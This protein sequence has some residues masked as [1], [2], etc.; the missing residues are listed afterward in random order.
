VSVNKVSKRTFN[1]VSGQKV[2]VARCYI[3]L[4][5]ILAKPPKAESKPNEVPIH[6]N[7]TRINEHFGDEGNSLSRMLS[8]KQMVLYGQTLNNLNLVFKLHNRAF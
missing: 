4:V 7:T 8:G 6:L 3:E 1:R 2:P 5:E